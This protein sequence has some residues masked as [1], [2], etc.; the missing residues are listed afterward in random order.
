MEKEET[1]E[2]KDMTINAKDQIIEVA[3]G[4]VMVG[5]INMTK[6]AKNPTAAK[7][8]INHFLHRNVMSPGQNKQKGA[9]I[10]II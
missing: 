7:I 5:M 8:A 4:N 9:K 10:A 3:L 1:F 2:D 6:E